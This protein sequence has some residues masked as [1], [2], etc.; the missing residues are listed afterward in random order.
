MSIICSGQIN[1]A[2][3]STVN[4]QRK[5]TCKRTSS[6]P[7]SAMRQECLFVTDIPFFPLRRALRHRL[8]LISQAVRH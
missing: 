5:N 2:E 4:G 8:R 1:E 3:E 6:T 7:L